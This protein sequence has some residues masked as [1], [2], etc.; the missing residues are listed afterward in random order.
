LVYTCNPL[1]LLE[2]R[3]QVIFETTFIKSKIGKQ[4]NS[5][6]V[7]GKKESNGLARAPALSV[8]RGAL[9]SAGGWLLASPVTVVTIVIR[10]YLKV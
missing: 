6:T 2:K 7:A 1:F 5:S 3:L 9:S 8:E 10:A 4:S